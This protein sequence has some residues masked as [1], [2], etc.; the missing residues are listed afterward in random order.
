M[1]GVVDRGSGRFLQGVPGPRIGAKTGTA[2]YGDARPPRT[3]GWMIAVRGDLAVAV[4][5]QD[6]VSGSQTA[7]PLLAAFLRGQP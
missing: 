2:E 6:A 1:D 5:V 4:F 7:G 3:H